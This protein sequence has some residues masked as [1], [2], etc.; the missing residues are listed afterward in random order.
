MLGDLLRE[1]VLELLRA[2]FLESLGQRVREHFSERI[3][4]RRVRRHR[5]VWR[6]L[7]RRHR[8]RLL[9]RLT[10]EAARKL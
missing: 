9:H 8:D 4:Q 10:T 1:I 3:R 5:A 6:S 2:L 7:H